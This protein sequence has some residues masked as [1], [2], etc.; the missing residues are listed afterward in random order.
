MML[1]WRVLNRVRFQTHDYWICTICMEEIRFIVFSTDPWITNVHY[2]AFRCLQTNF[3]LATT[4]LQ[5]R[6]RSPK[7]RRPSLLRWA[8]WRLPRPPWSL[9]SDC[10]W[11]SERT[12]HSQIS[13]CEPSGG[14]PANACDRGPVQVW[15]LSPAELTCKIAT[16]STHWHGQA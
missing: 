5:T 16:V 12:T 15:A 2:C 11:T 10:R 7:T 6:K 9:R 3:R 1:Y 14:S 4:S 13:V 8:W